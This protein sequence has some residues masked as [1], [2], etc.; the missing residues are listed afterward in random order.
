MTETVPLFV[1]QEAL[2]YYPVSTSCATRWTGWVVDVFLGAAATYAGTAAFQSFVLVASPAKRPD[3]GQVDIPYISSATQKIGTRLSSDKFPALA[4]DTDYVTVQPAALELDADAIL[5]IVVTGYLRTPT[6]Y[7]FCDPDLPPY[8]QTTSDGWEGSWKTSTWNESVWGI[9]SNATKFD[10]LGDLCFNT[11][12]ILRQQTTLTSRVVASGHSRQETGSNGADID[13]GFW[14]RDIYSR[15]YIDTLVALCVILNFLLMI[16][17][18]IPYKLRIRSIQP[19]AI[20]RERREIYGD[21]K[22]KFWR[23]VAASKS[24]N[25]NQEDVESEQNKIKLLSILECIRP[26]FSIQF[27]KAWI[28]FILDMVVLV[29]LLFSIIISPLTVIAFVV[30][31]E[32][33]IRNDGP[34]QESPQQVGQWSYLLSIGLLLISA[35]ILKLKYRLASQKELDYI[36]DKTRRHLEELQNIRVEKFG[37]YHRL[38][39]SDV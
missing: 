3:P 22:A 31:I 33:Y 32:W 17:N 38:S 21:L 5:A 7:M 34:S 23:A 4:T 27:L 39:D 25:T 1:A 24:Q 16:F 18:L 9:F 13:G 2:C 28:H 12:Q 15:R 36:I 14:N 29:G 11:S 20:W 37:N 19:V 35:A 8:E 26:L 30:W 6:Q 10:Q